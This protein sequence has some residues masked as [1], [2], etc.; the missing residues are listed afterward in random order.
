MK[1]LKMSEARRVV[2][3]G[4]GLVSPIGND[5]DSFWN[6][7]SNGKSGID[8]LKRVPGGGIATNISG[9]ASDFTG[10]IT[11]FGDLSKGQ[12]RSI[13][14]NKKV[15]CREIEMGV[16]VAQKS[17]QHAGIVVGEHDPDR[18]GVIYG[19]D[20]IMTE[21]YE[22]IEAIR[23]TVS[24]DG[25]FQFSEW[26][27]KGIPNIT[28]LWLLKYLPNMPASHIAI[29]NDFRGTNNSITLRESAANLA[30]GEAFCT[31]VRGKADTVVSGATGTRIHP[32]RSMHVSLQEQLAT[33]ESEPTTASRP[34]DARRSGLVIGEGA[35]AVILEELEHAVH[36]GAQI[37]G[38]VVG[39][40]SSTV[41]SKSG[42]VDFE[43][44]LVNSIRSVLRTSGEVPGNVGHVNAHG[45][46][47]RKCDAGEARAIAGT[48]DTDDRKIPVIAPKSYFGNLGAGSGAVE[49]IGS[50]N[51]LAAGHL[52]KTLN[53]D[54]PDPG[55][56]IHVVTDADTVSG[57]SFIN[58]NV[59]PFGQASAVMVK[60]F[61]A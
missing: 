32:L 61:V 55:C 11:D 2:I 43:K 18:T 16:A 30:I 34:F 14:R 44:S 5:P 48:L 23:K 27:A 36:R 39:Y 57:D 42:I 50:L 35:A 40:G 9:E 10:E 52:I 25:E 15:M 28:P 17:I 59:T 33:T 58:L 4:Y 22:F 38:E 1:L 51:C 60:R 26:A 6:A 3:T 54:T 29:Y 41:I 53:Y 13:K 21:P 49:L 24:E 12:K 47:A 31:I 7:L 46:S 19:S 45:L 56:P 8:F 37:Y 20:Y